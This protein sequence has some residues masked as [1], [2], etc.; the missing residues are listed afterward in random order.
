M[1][2]LA[3]HIERCIERREFCLVFEEELERCWPSQRI[4]RAEREEQI[5]TFA[6]LHGWSAFILD[7]ESGVTRAIFRHGS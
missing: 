3:N 5:Q 1:D 6:E 7:T 4:E 2:T